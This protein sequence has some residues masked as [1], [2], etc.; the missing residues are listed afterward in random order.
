[1]NTPEFIH[2]LQPNEVFVFGSNQYAQ[3]EAGSAKAA[4]KFGAIYRDVPIGL[5]GQS[6]GILTTSY[7]DLPV[8]LEFI[9]SQVVVLYH[10]ALL[11]Q[12]LTFLVTKVGTGIA[13]F[14]IE[15]IAGVFKSMTFKPQNIILP[16]EFI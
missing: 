10:F 2:H 16:I 15:E 8:T 14:T 9:K 3:H 12:D 11:R 13:G 1:M 4:I 7:S 5:C 6:Y